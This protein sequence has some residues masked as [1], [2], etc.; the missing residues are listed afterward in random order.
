MKKIYP[1]LKWL[2]GKKTTI[3]TIL[4][5]FVTYLQGIG[6]I[7]NHLALFLNSTLIALGYTA[8]KATK[9]MYNKK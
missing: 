2:Q 3:L 6:A 9:S 1:A 4:A 5:L 8:S 7:D